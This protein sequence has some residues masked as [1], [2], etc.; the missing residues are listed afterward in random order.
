MRKWC[1]NLF[2]LLALAMFP[3]S[4]IA[5]K[6]G[7]DP[8][9]EL[10]SPVPNNEYDVA[11][12]AIASDLAAQLDRNSALRVAV[13]E[14]TDLNGHV[15]MQSRAISETLTIFLVRGGRGFQILDRANLDVL[16]RERLQVSSG[17]LD[18]E[19][20]AELGR[21]AGLDTVIVGTV[22]PR[23]DRTRV[24]VRAISVESS[25][26]IAAALP[27]EISTDSSQLRL[28]EPR[29]ESGG[30]LASPE[31][32]ANDPSPQLDIA[33]FPEFPA[34]SVNGLRFEV[35]R[36]LYVERSERLR[37]VFRL[38]N[39]GPQEINIGS[40]DLVRFTM[41]GGESCSG[42]PSFASEIDYR[43][44]LVLSPASSI[45][46][47]VDARYCSDFAQAQQADLTFSVNLISPAR[48]PTA[49]V[50]AAVRGVR[51]R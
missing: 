41:F 32:A 6:P 37:A 50:E 48:R 20:V 26:V 36:L 38:E 11:I 51:V 49:V 8:I 22:E 33:V 16:I 24:Q 18:P 19:T 2:I 25:R 7:Q 31:S 15:T 3:S 43:N 42:Q 27:R 9:G 28:A 5:E 44:P 30:T 12:A 47:A 46:F 13:L 40:I 45:L 10:S 21:I 1:Y 39:V 23:A 35:Y 17:I 4:A 29:L 34:T 14:F